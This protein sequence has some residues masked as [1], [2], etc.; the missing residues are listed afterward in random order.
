MFKA[1]PISSIGS[2]SWS[3]FPKQFSDIFS[4]I[5]DIASYSKVASVPREFGSDF[6]LLGL[7]I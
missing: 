2:I 5:T 3:S 1:L 7:N 6:S 4:S